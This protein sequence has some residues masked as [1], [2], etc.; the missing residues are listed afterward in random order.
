MK[1]KLV[2]QTLGLGLGYWLGY[3]RFSP[4]PI[5]ETNAPEIRQSD[6]SLVLERNI[7]ETKI[8]KKPPIMPFRK[9]EWLR[10][11]EVTIKPNASLIASNGEIKPIVVKLDLIRLSDKTYRVIANAEGGEVI[12]GI[13][14]PIETTHYPDPPKWAAGGIILNNG[15]GAFIQRSVGAFLIGL[16]VTQTTH[17]AV[18]SK[19]LGYSLRIGVRF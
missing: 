11:T 12:G 13:D 5:I 15:Y 3:T 1:I 6:G 2:I 7:S 18:N 16:D 4:K 10:H 8:P 17:K 19:D 9:S 14:V